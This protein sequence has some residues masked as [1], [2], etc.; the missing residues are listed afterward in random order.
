MAIR[1][2]LGTEFNVEHVKRMFYA[3]GYTLERAMAPSRPEHRA[4]AQSSH[5]TTLFFKRR[6]AAVVAVIYRDYDGDTDIVLNTVTAPEH[7]K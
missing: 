6:D 4:A 7:A 3:E 2:S 5:G 1:N